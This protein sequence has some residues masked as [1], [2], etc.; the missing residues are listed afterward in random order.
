MYQANPADATQ[1]PIW[2][3]G[4]RTMFSAFHHLDPIQ[5]RPALADAV[6]HGEGIAVFE[7]G[8]RSILMLPAVLPV[9]IRIL[10]ASLLFGPSVGPRS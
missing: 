5:A 8:Q 9:P 1:V 3:P 6:A 7:G 10:L 4:F 2:L